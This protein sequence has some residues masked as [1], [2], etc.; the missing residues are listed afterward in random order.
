MKTRRVLYIVILIGLLTGMNT[1]CSTAIP[2][3]SKPTA[4]PTP[5]ETL[6]PTPSPTA[7]STFTPTRK[8]TKNWSATSAAKN[9]L[10]MD[11]KI[12]DVKARFDSMGISTDT[13]HLGWTQSGILSL[14]VDFTWGWYPKNVGDNLTASDFAISSDVSW[15]ATNIVYCGFIFRADLNLQYGKQYQILFRRVSG[16]PFWKIA[17]WKDFGEQNIITG[18]YISSGDLKMENGATNNITLVVQDNKFEVYINGI[19]QGVYYDYSKQATSG[20]IAALTWQDAGSSTCT[21][22]NT[23]IW[24]YK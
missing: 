8:P 1:A 17:F 10:Q 16:L 2:L 3:F 14:P 24:V 4:T 6:I 20:Q 21:Y 5:T 11:A 9:T 7:S 22:K 12:A 15:T 23:V 13:G 19:Y 18:D